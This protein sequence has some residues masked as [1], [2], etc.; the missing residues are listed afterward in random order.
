M[1]VKCLGEVYQE[2]SQADTAQDAEDEVDRVEEGERLDEE[3]G[4][5]VQ[6]HEAERIT[7]EGALPEECGRGDALCWYILACQQVD[8]RVAGKG[9][10][11]TRGGV[12]PGSVGEAIDYQPREESEEEQADGLGADGHLQQDIDVEERR[13]QAQEVDV[14]QYQYL[15]G[16]EDE[17]VYSYP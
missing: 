4:D 2:D 6:H 15:D 7:Q 16:E 9:G 13:G 3:E 5:V 8:K 10:E 12:H 17:A 11:A 14:V 1:Q